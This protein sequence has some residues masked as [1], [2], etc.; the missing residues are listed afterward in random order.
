MSTELMRKSFCEQA[1]LVRRGEVSAQE[2]TL[3][4]IAEIERLNPSSM[5][6]RSRYSIT[7]KNS[8]RHSVGM[9]RTPVC[10]SC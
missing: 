10:H 5:P 9:S 7:R 1:E 3:A 8:L 2:L 4:A 6:L